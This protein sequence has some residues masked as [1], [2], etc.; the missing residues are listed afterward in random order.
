MNPKANTLSIS[1][2][3]RNEEQHLGRLLTNAHLY[4][5]EII[6]LDTGS[7]DRTK[8]IALACGA[9]VF[10]FKWC[11]DFA[12][13]RNVS[14]NHCTKDFVMWLDA[15]DVISDESAHAIAALMHNEIKWDV[16]YFPYYV[17]GTI[18]DKKGLCK[19][20]PRIFRNRIGVQW[21]HPIHECLNYTQRVNKERNIPGI[22]VHHAPLRDGIS[23]PLRNLRILMNVCKKKEYQ[24][25]DY[26]FWH[27]GK[28]FSALNNPRQAIHNLKRGVMFAAHE[29][30]TT[31][32]QY[33]ALGVQY[34]R[35]QQFQAALEAFGKSGI[36]YPDWR[37]PFVAMAECYREL[38]EPIA[39]ALGLEVAQKITR[40]NAHI[41]R[42]EIYED[43][44]FSQWKPQKS[45]TNQPVEP[46][47]KAY[48]LM[49]G[50]DLM[51]A[52]QM[53]GYI[54]KRGHVRP[55]QPLQAIFSEADVVLANL[56]CSL[57]H[58]GE[59]MDKGGRKP[60]Y[61]LARPDV[62][63]V[64]I[65]AGINLLTLANNH[66]LD[67]G[68]ESV[69]MQRELLDACGLAH[70]GVG[71]NKQEAAKPAY[72]ETGECRVAVI[73]I[74]TETMELAVKEGRPGVFHAKGSQAI[75]RNLAGAIAMAKRYA[76]IV[77]VS[78]HW[79]DNWIENPNTEQQTLARAII[80]LGADA[81]L[82]HSAHI[83]QGVEVYREKPIVYD[84]GTLLFDRVQENRMKY[85][86]LFDLTYTQNG[87]TSL[88][89]HPLRLWG[90]STGMASGEDAKMVRDL[91]ITLSSAL[92]DGAQFEQVGEGLHLKLHA[93]GHGFAP[94]ARPD[95]EEIF[96]KSNLSSVP[97]HFK[98]VPNP[99]VHT[100]LPRDLHAR[101][102]V[103]FDQG[104]TFLGARY[105]EA[106][107]TGRGFLAELFFQVEGPLTSRWEG[108]IVG[109]LQNGEDTFEY[110][111][112]I[113]EGLY[114]CQEWKAGEIIMDR[115]IVRP[116][117]GL[118]SG[119][120]D[121][122]WGLVN[123]DDNNI[124]CCANKIHFGS[125]VFSQ[126]VPRGVAGIAWNGK[127]PVV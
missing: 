98:S 41:Q 80:D 124:E 48:R 50:G 58:G 90:G 74:E 6:V 88:R 21:I 35:L 73:A 69:T 72:V 37:E 82:G 121:L 42:A 39:S 118:S 46:T 110:I 86:A 1:M 107:F 66:A 14:L 28:E 26:M 20:T 92:P 125:I 27:V 53:P 36:A 116:I 76:H 29:G 60:F 70:A 97:R 54:A 84:M 89:I 64:A 101:Q 25:S 114:P 119:V 43:L 126:D 4:A 123:R 22:A 99:L 65:K 62:L 117:N 71:V 122:Y 13:A 16:A 38:G 32:R 12:A 7:V 15:D 24:H 45:N 3:V 33:L 63:D 44:F 55:L 127:L 8:E 17:S 91:L 111:H 103:A 108:I 59:F 34:Q 109:K 47:G 31:S 83:L 67:A 61:Y 23:S 85:S 106:V 51:L 19:I 77:V 2:I 96:K 11:D 75:L 87:F 113:G 30:L 100:T 10:D 9:K 68:R 93:R 105:A 49:A 52:R 18:G 57:T 56:E 5:D 78:P 102:T 115:T 95:P 81:I 120:Y 112:P 94:E 104:I 40:H 79:G